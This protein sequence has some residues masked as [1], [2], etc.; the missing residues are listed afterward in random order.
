MQTEFVWDGSHL[1]QEI[2]HK[3]DRTYT[4]IYSHANSYEPLA[5]IYTENGEQVVNYFHCDQLV[6]RVK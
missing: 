6:S 4:Y 1:V 3:V 2:D 5:Q